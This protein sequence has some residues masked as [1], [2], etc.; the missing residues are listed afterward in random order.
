MSMRRKRNI[1]NF[2]SLDLSSTA[3]KPVRRRKRNFHVVLFMILFIFVMI[4]LVWQTRARED[5]KTQLVEEISN[6][7]QMTL[8]KQ[9]EREAEEEAKALEEQALA[10]KK[11]ELQQLFDEVGNF[12]ALSYEQAY[13]ISSKIAGEYARYRIDEEAKQLA[14]DLI[15]TGANK[16]KRQYIQTF[17]EKISDLQKE[18]EEVAGVKLSGSV[19]EEARVY[20][21]YL[22]RVFR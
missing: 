3:R 8:Q 11:M 22:L 20:A 21:D 13:E 1:D 18:H 12:S 17:K 16:E 6:L 19:Y 14:W 4:M 15:T 2:G 5:T 9:I 10:E 7:E